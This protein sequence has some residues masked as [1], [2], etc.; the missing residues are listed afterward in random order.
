ME[1]NLAPDCEQEHH[2]CVMVFYA[3]TVVDPRTVMIKSFNAAV[4]DGTMS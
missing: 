3:N 2:E 1:Y 4:A